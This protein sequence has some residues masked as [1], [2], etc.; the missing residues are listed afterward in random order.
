MKKILPEIAVLTIF[1]ALGILLAMGLGFGIFWKTLEPIT[2]MNVFAAEFPYFILPTV[3]ML[4]PA[5]ISSIVL[6]IRFKNEKEIRKTWLYVMSGMIAAFVITSAYHLPVNLGFIQ[7]KYTAE[8]ITTLL[9]IWLLLHWVRF[10]AVFMAA[11][12]A[13][14]GFKQ[15]NQVVQKI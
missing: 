7:L 15:I 3:L 1:G 4:Q 5:L 12:F 13:L 6:F 8:E 10:A 14:K 11:V 2:F 9:N